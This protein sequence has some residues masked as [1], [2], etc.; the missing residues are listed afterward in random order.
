MSSGSKLADISEAL[1]SLE[2]LIYGFAALFFVLI[3]YF[4]NPVRVEQ[5]RMRWNLLH[6]DIK[7]SFLPAFLKGIAIATGLTLAWI[8]T[9]Y[10]RYVGFMIQSPDPWLGISN[11]FFRWI[12][13]LFL[14]LGEEYLFRKRLQ[15]RLSP[16]FSPVIAVG[17]TSLLYAAIKLTQFDLGVTQTATLFLIS[18]AL[19]LR[20]HLGKDAFQGAGLFS[21]FLIALHAG[22][23]LPILGHSFNGFFLINYR[24][25][26]THLTSDNGQTF[27]FF[28]GGL[29]GPLSSLA[30]QFLLTVWI[31]RI[32]LR[33]KKN[34]LNRPVPSLE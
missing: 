12:S 1:D 29:G 31:T 5:D 8:L 2:I 16:F 13:L 25:E 18:T 9:G 23:G 24:A 32:L 27:L 14:V 28:T 4:G 30:L 22:A 3:L 20:A 17:I 26:L 10:Y 15:E 6:L 34:L 7:H 19:G 33:H 11:I 21:G